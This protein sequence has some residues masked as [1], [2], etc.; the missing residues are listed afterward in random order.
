MPCGVWSLVSYLFNDFFS[1]FLP[2]LN[3]KKNTVSWDYLFEN[4]FTNR[5][6]KVKECWSRA[7]CVAGVLRTANLSLWAA[8]EVL[9]RRFILERLVFMEESGVDWETLVFLH[10]K[11]DFIELAHTF[12]WNLKKNLFHAPYVWYSVQ[13]KFLL[14][15][16]L[17][18]DP[19]NQCI[20]SLFHLIFFILLPSKK[21]LRGR[22]RSR[23]LCSRSWKS[24]R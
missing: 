11:Q 18:N 19:E 23:W 8:T 15:A 9:Q 1:L 16:G 13:T 22:S 14:K 2:A 5:F 20:W 10:L 3:L 7:W 21:S 24:R 6:T 4:R 12:H 17:I